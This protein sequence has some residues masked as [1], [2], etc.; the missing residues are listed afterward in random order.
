MYCVFVDEE[1]IVYWV[2]IFDVLA[3]TVQQPGNLILVVCSSR[4][5]GKNPRFV[6]LSIHV[7]SI[8]ATLYLNVNWA[9]MQGGRQK[10]KPLIFVDIFAKY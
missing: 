2:F 10:S 3:C 4:Y 8:D 9:L 1:T 5:Y 7:A 6:L